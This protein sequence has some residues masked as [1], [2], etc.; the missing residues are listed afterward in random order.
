MRYVLRI[1]VC[2]YLY[3]IGPTRTRHTRLSREAFWKI[4]WAIEAM[5]ATQRE[6][7]FC[8]GAMSRVFVLA[9]VSLASA[10]LPGADTYARAALYA[11][12]MPRFQSFM[13]QD[14]E[15]KFEP[16]S[17]RV[18]GG[19]EPPHPNG[20]AELVLYATRNA[21]R[22]FE[23]A[24]RGG[25]TACANSNGTAEAAVRMHAEALHDLERRL[26]ESGRTLPGL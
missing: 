14:G 20:M 26:L 21:R 7:C 4:E 5:V 9:V 17:T 18:V 15:L 25:I 11:I 3:P 12:D 10:A 22:A 16:P 8:D 2:P 6:R 23:L 24:P 1:R 13:R 19:G